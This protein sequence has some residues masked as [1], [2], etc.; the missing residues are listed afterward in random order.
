M[1]TAL[2]ELEIV[3]NPALGAYAIWRFGLSFQTEEGRPPSL[4]LAFL[5][6]PLVLHRPTL[7]VIIFNSQ[8]FWACVVCRQTWRGAREPSCSSCAG[9]RP[10]TTDPPVRRH[11]CKSPV[12][13]A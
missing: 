11:G 3:Q 13:N 7:E 9:S 12:A 4:P 1:T 10:S 8:S 6:L 5:V 2:S